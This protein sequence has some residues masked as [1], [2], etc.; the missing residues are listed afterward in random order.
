MNNMYAK[1]KCTD[2]NEN[3]GARM[4]SGDD[5]PFGYMMMMN[6][7]TMALNQQVDILPPVKLNDQEKAEL[8]AILDRYERL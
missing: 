4:V 7:N 5:K 3:E 8:N 6:L 1:R 2:M